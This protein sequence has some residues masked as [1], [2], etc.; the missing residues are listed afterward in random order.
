[1]ASLFT[2][3]NIAKSGLMASQAALETTSQ[4][5]SNAD[6]PGYTRQT[7]D[8]NSA[9]PDTGVY[10][11]VNDTNQAGNGVN[12]SGVSQSRDSFLDVRYR[13]ANSE[14]SDWQGQSDA[15]SSIEDIFNEFSDNTSDGSIGLSGQMT[16][17]QTALQQYQNTPTDTTLP[18]TINL[19]SIQSHLR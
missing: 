17:L 2:G 8:M 7:I 4:N 6:T 14:H 11:M 1:M 15:L 18:T 13:G 19:Q 9:G 12:I 3:L 10:R 16:N 5:I